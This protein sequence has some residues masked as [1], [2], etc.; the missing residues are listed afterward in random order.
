MSGSSTVFAGSPFCG[1]QCQSE[2]QFIDPI[3]ELSDNNCANILQINTEQNRIETLQYVTENY[4]QVFV[5]HFT[6]LS[7][8]HKQEKEGD[9]AP[10]RHMIRT[11][12]LCHVTQALALKSGKFVVF[13]A[14]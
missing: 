8:V 6:F 7:F 2:N 14:D 10:C 1:E 9:N 5:S 3:K 13:E 4:C 11:P 12:T